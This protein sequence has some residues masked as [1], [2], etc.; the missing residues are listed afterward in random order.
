MLEFI[1]PIDGDCVNERDG[2][3][4][5]N[6][7][8]V[9]VKVK[10]DENSD[11]YI[12]GK[13]AEYQDGV[14]SMDVEFCGYRNIVVAEDRA[15]GE[16]KKIAGYYLPNAVKKFRV[17][18]DDNIIFLQD[19]TKNKD[20][21]NSIFE[22]PYLAIY[23]KAH[24][25]YG[26]KVHLNLFYEFHPEEKTRFSDKSREYFD[27]SMMTDK[28]KSEWQA[29][30]DWLKLNFHAKSDKPDKPYIWIYWF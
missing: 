4:T 24:E 11:V 6:G 21:Y 29:N 8:C 26:A 20:V 13:K 10:A 1:F 22:N 5:Q 7:V 27:L 15:N 12:C 16:E 2:S 9:N 14:Y 28:F 3:A 30:S 25:L 17:S 18:S 23:K 19:I